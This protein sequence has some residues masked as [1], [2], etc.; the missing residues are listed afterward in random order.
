MATKA[1]E[2]AEE[3]TNFRESITIKR[4]L[5]MKKYADDIKMKRLFEKSRRSGIRA[6]GAPHKPFPPLRGPPPI[7]FKILLE[8]NPSL[9]A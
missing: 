2:K 4:T 1:K 8:E 6:S 7:D 5:F 3:S 9:V